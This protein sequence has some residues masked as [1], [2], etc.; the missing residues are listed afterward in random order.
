MKCPG[1]K[2]WR[3]WRHKLT[4]P[5]PFTHHEIF[6]T[7]NY[8][9]KI[10]NMIDIVEIHTLDS[11]TC[12]LLFQILWSVLDLNHDG[13]DVT[14]SP[15]SHQMMQSRQ[16]AN[17]I[18]N[19]QYISINLEFYVWLVTICKIE[20]LLHL[21]NSFRLNLL[22]NKTTV[23]SQSDAPNREQRTTSNFGNWFKTVNQFQSACNWQV[24]H[25]HLICIGS[26]NF[27]RID[28]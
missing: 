3:I 16:K 23:T 25:C 8:F 22:V 6:T 26:I 12:L 14:N 1:L 10:V 19:S 7:F 13:C 2:L 4:P 17:Y 21:G 24:K 28:A 18:S 20:Y 5:P 9:L 15:A 11:C 27:N